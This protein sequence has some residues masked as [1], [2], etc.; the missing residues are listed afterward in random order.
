MSTERPAGSLALDC[1]VL[2]QIWLSRDR[3]CPSCVDRT[4][5][6]GRGDVQAGSGGP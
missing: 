4:D 6:E 2:Q 3:T 1:E 5:P